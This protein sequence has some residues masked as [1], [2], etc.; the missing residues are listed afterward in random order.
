MD[1]HRHQDVKSIA[2][3]KSTFAK[4]VREIAEMKDDLDSASR[5]EKALAALERRPVAAS[6]PPPR[7]A[8]AKDE[9]LKTSVADPKIQTATG[10]L[11][12][13]SQQDFQK[14]LTEGDTWVVM[15]YAPWCGH[16]TA[17]KPEFQQAA[18]QAPVHFAQIDAD[19]Y[20]DIALSE[21]IP[22]FPTIRVYSKGK[23]VGSFDGQ[24]TAVALLEFAK[25][26]AS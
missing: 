2:E 5:L 3:L 12:E 23:Q 15:F 10:G 18:L 19:K 8:A 24:R 20:G 25:S 1:E 6:P 13:L 9:T 4:L 7:R 17:A 26:Y 16:C 11:V 14:L 22:G 21:S